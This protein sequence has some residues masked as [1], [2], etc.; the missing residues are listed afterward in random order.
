MKIVEDR[1]TQMAKFSEAVEKI[2]SELHK[3]MGMK[4][5]REKLLEGVQ[6]GVK[7]W[8]RLMNSDDQ[9][10][11]I[12]KHIE[13]MKVSDVNIKE[14]LEKDSLSTKLEIK[15]RFEEVCKVMEAIDLTG[16]ELVVD[17]VSTFKSKLEEAEKLAVELGSK[18]D[19]L[20]ESITG[21]V[22]M[23]YFRVALKQQYC[24]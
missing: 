5:T 1:E 3:L 23:N 7:D 8:Q 10:E 20:K 4:Y 19:K 24:Y 6:K 11:L 21:N 18:L 14:E 12:Q 22:C 13:Q 15:E 9:Y 2:K 17:E 16:W